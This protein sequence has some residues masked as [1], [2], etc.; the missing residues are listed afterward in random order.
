[1]AV[2]GDRAEAAAA[3]IPAT[4]QA[5]Q[6]LGFHAESPG[7]GGAIYKRIDGPPAANVALSAFQNV[8]GSWWQA[9]LKDGFATP[10]MMG[11]REVR[12]T[13]APYD[14]PFWQAAAH[15]SEG[16]IRVEARRGRHYF[17]HQEIKVP[18]YSPVIEGPGANL[19]TW[20]WAVDGCQRT[21]TLGAPGVTCG[22]PYVK[23]IRFW[24]P[25]DDQF[26]QAPKPVTMFYGGASTTLVVPSHGFSAGTRVYLK[27]LGIPALDR[28]VFRVKANP[29]DY[30][31]G[32]VDDKT[33]AD[34]DTTT[35]LAW[36]TGGTVQKVQY[37]ID[38][39]V[40]GVINPNE[41]GNSWHLRCYYPTHGRIEMCSFTGQGRNVWCD[42]QS[43]TVFEQCDVAGIWDQYRPGLQLTEADFWLSS[44]G[45]PRKDIQGISHGPNAALTS[46]AHG[47]SEGAEVYIFDLPQP[48]ELNNRSFKIEGVNP[49][50]FCLRD[51]ITGQMVNTSAMP[52]YAGGGKVRLINDG[53]LDNH[54]Q[55]KAS[56]TRCVIEGVGVPPET[57]GQNTQILR[58][59]TVGNVTKMQR[60]NI[61]SRYGIAA[62]NFEGLD[63]E[64]NIIG[65]H[66]RAG[67]LLE[68]MPYGLPSSSIAMHAM[69]ARNLM[70]GDIIASLLVEPGETP[71]HSL[72]YIDNRANGGDIV[73]HQVRINHVPGRPTV[74]RAV[75]RGNTGQGYRK[76]P[77]HLEGV[78]GGVVSENPIG[79]WNVFDVRTNSPE[80][81]DCVYVHPSSSNLIVHS[82]PMGGGINDPAG[83]FRGRR[84]V[85]IISDPYATHRHFGNRLIPGGNDM[86]AEGYPPGWQQDCNLPDR[87]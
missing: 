17:T 66:N 44:V 61:G 75:I 52:A 35:A 19:T 24:K 77:L 32:L 84:A 26:L 34:I 73:D 63:V 38:D 71:V 64:N 22:S 16:K 4:R 67:I 60:E 8:D 48:T 5:I 30:A 80:I 57:P 37:G 10:E 55:T 45:G 36:V 7:L 21:M 72:H 15:L 41:Y 23:G 29:I 6:I 69:I 51:T 11:A 56:I 50:S 76:S 54:I 85:S 27:G 81:T 86:A 33:G 12:P 58:P 14:W 78:N 9:Q 25:R 79:G 59:I 47:F 65:G 68:S 1:M 53:T 82:N 74:A 43:Y 20:L 2:Y 3:V 42:Q 40:V 46:T 62:F 83:P 49:N 18:Y 39:N 31:F 70:D 13:E 87:I 28:K